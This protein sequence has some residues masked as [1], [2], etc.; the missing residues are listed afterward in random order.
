MA[1]MDANVPSVIADMSG[2]GTLLSALH[3]NL[4]DN[5]RHCANVGFTHYEAAE[6]GPG[7]IAERSALFFAPG[8]I[9]KRRT[10]WG[11]GV[12]ERKSFQFWR[13]AAMR[14]RAWLRIEPFTGME[15]L[16]TAY[17]GVLNRKFAADQGVVVDL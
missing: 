8:H 4:R 14:S 11:P 5:M 6:L 9:Q 15:G 1:S 3:E 17:R 16:E 12:F 13:D 7:F 2:N 10:D